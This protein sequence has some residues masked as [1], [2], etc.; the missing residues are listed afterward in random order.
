MPLFAVVARAGLSEPERGAVLVA[1]LGDKVLQ[2]V[3]DRLVDGPREVGKRARERV[4]VGGVD[5]LLLDGEAD[6]EEPGKELREKGY[7]EAKELMRVAGKVK[8]YGVGS[9]DILQ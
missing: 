2:L 8:R 3:D 1:G 9:E 7:S 6:G 4:D 5:Q